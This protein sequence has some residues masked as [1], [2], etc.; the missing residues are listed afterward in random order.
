[1][2]P[3]VLDLSIPPQDRPRLVYGGT[4]ACV[5]CAA[6]LAVGARGR[7]HGPDLT[8]LASASPVIQAHLA[9]A[10][11]ALV[12]G[13]LLMAG[14]KGRTLHKR[15]GWTWVIAMGTVAASSFFIRTINP[16]HFSWIHLLSGWTVIGL[17]LAIVAVQRRR[18]ATHRRFMTGLYLGGLIIAGAFTFVPGRLL[19]RVF[20]G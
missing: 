19:W 17:P 10:L 4:L 16:G 1:M 2:K 12:I 9:A 6:A 14:P 15:L 13:G 5:L 20:L 8:L 7:P 3:P 11:L 18:L